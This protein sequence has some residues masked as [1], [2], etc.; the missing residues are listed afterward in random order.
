MAFDK[1]VRE[2]EKLMSMED[3]KRLV[4]SRIKSFK[5]ALL[6]PAEEV[7]KE[8]VFCI[9]AANF[10]AS[11]SLRI[12][13]ELGDKLMKLDA[14]GLALELR[15]LGHKYPEVRARYIVEA[16]MKLPEIIEALR[17]GWGEHELRDWL[18]E[19]VRGLG[20][21]EAS[22]LLRNL[23]YGNIAIIDFHILRVLRRYGVVG[24]FR[25]LTRRRYLEIEGLLR[26]L[27]K[28]LGISLAELDL[29]LW[30]MDTGR[31]VK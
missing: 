13:E 14:D 12:V 17:S 24:E 16:R 6:K 8:I 23:G 7:F 11:R 26:E 20:I 21:K 19:N 3:I 30:Y 15:R 27:A 22:H 31:I 1:L 28:R 29:Y 2:L 5:E 10:A 25:S 9:L 18:T 4:E